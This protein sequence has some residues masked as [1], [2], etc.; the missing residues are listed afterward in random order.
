MRFHPLVLGAVAAIGLGSPRSADAC[1]IGGC[2]DW[3][4]DCYNLKA[5]KWCA[6]DGVSKVTI[7]NHGSYESALDWARN[8]ISN[9]HNGIGNSLTVTQVASG[10]Q[11]DV[12]DYSG[13][14][15]WWGLADQYVTTNGT[16][17]SSAR[18][19]INKSYMNSTIRKQYTMLHEIGH[20]VG[21][22]HVCVCPRTMNPCGTCGDDGGNDTPYLK[23]CDAKGLAAKYPESIAAPPDVGVDEILY[24]AHLL[25]PGAHSDVNGDG[26]ADVCARAAAG[27]LCQLS[28]ETG[29]AEVIAGPALDDDSGWSDFDNA[30][31]LRTLDMDGDGLADLCARA[32][33]GIRCWKSTGAGFGSSIEG[34]A[35]SDE[36]SWDDPMYFTTLR[37][38]DFDADGKD[39]L[40]VRGAKNFRCYRSNGSGFSEAVPGPELSNDG[41][42]SKI[43]RYATIRMGDVDGNGKADVCGRDATGMRCWLSDGAG[44]PTEIVGPAWADASGWDDSMY[45]ATIRLADVDADGKADLCARAASGYR[46]HLSTGDGFGEAVSGPEWSN[47]SGWSDYDNWSTIRL[48]DVDADGDLDLCARANAGIRCVKWDGS[49]FSGSFSGPDLS[50]EAGWD[51]PQH[52][53]TLR[54]ADVNGD[55]KA[56]LCARGVEGLS[57]WLSDGEGFPTMVDGPAWS[58]ASGWKDAKYYASIRVTTAPL[59]APD[60][61]SGGAGASGA[62]TGAGGGAAGSGHGAGAAEEAAEPDDPVLAGSCECGIGKRNPSN[63]VSI[64]VIGGLAAFASRRRRRAARRR[65]A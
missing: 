23:T 50:D 61:G 11:L 7:Q 14:A 3:P 30:T 21:L 22:N 31:T 43:E 36:N 48:G 32:N 9:P 60:D 64:V 13:S 15:D 52:F 25:D 29:F 34:P 17:M 59:Q 46:C 4:S 45:Y 49:G 58:D 57:C 47:E 19:Q 26:I 18:I 28:T 10:G 35:F 56:D 2:P 39:D 20:A 37:V 16:C 53:R 5:T 65:A 33:A 62:S 42:W 40:C 12:Y 54:L 63:T 55:R 44:F 51:E 24:Q 38:A 8:E 1:S 27:V 6:K 41:G